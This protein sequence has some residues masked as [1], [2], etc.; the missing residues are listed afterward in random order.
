MEW[1]EW[2]LAKARQER[3]GG[4][5][6]GGRRKRMQEGVWEEGRRRNRR[7]E[8]N[9][10]GRFGGEAKQDV[11]GRLKGQKVGMKREKNKGHI[12]GLMAE[13]RAGGAKTKRG[14]CSFPCPTV[15][16]ALVV[17]FQAA[18]KGGSPGSGL[19]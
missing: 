18:W 13:R 12:W 14:C 15:S 11:M 5:G 16:F 8:T 17:V 3:R 4:G 9:I 1:G 6:V 19:S 7:W 10:R 2:E